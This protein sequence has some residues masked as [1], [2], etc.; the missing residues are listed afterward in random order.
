VG[1]LFSTVDGVNAAPTGPQRE[2]FAELQG[3]FAERMSE[4]HKFLTETVSKLNE[5]LRRHNAPTVAAG[6]EIEVHR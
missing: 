2:F 1:S 4:A 3:E 6:K 5:T